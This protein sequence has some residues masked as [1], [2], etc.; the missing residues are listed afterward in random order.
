MYYVYS[1]IFFPEQLLLNRFS[2]DIVTESNSYFITNASNNG[3]LALL[4]ELFHKTLR[5]TLRCMATSTRHEAWGAIINLY[6]RPL[7][8]EGLILTPEF[9]FQAGNRTIF[10]LTQEKVKLH[11]FKVTQWLFS[12]YRKRFPVG[13]FY[14]THV[15]WRNFGLTMFLSEKK[16]ADPLAV[17]WHTYTFALRTILSGFHSNHIWC[18]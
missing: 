16:M 5:K 9:K 8:E 14:G 1:S 7:R 3:T 6:F 12:R 15:H 10:T 13:Y 17:T 18:F 2:S 11:V 4:L